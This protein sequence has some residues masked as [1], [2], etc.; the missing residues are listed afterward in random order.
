M[1]SLLLLVVF[2]LGLSSCDE[3]N[4]LTC[5]EMF[6]VASDMCRMR[7]DAISGFV[8]TEDAWGCAKSSR[9]T[10]SNPLTFP[11]L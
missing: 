5:D 1:R 7:G 2:A 9:Y 4:C 10:C 6:H 11:D 3:V 8:C